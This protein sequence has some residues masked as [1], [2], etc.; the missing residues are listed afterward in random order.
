MTAL[1]AKHG[2]VTPIVNR[3]PA[4]A[5]YYCPA[6]FGTLGVLLHPGTEPAPAGTPALRSA[7]P[8]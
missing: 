5:V 6:C 2:L 4:V 8:A 1:C 7:V 3:C